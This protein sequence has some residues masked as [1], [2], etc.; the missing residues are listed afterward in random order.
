M[1]R[2]GKLVALPVALAMAANL[3]PG[4]AE[5]EDPSAGTGGRTGSGGGGGGP[6]ASAGGS[7]GVEIEGGS[8]SGGF[9]PDSAC[10]LFSAAGKQAPAAILFVVDRSASMSL[11]QK[12][13]VAQQAV[14]TAIDR[15][16]FDNV[17]LG[18][19][20]FPNP[21]KVDP[22]QCLCDYACAGN[23]AI[24][25]PL[26]GGGVNC[27]FSG[28]PQVPLTDS[29][30]NK[31]NGGAGVRQAIYQYMLTNTPVTD[32]SDA[33][34]IYDALV[35]GYTSLENY[36][37]DRRVVVLITDGGFSCT[38]LASPPRPAYSDG[39]CDDWE[40]PDTVNTLIKAKYDANNRIHTFIIGV[41]GSD[42][43][44]GKQGSYATAPYPMR[45]ALSTYAVSGAPD[46]VP[47]SCDKT[48]VFSQSGSV[49]AAPCHFDL[50]Q[51]QLQVDQ[52]AQSLTQ[53][54]GQALGCLFDLPDPTGGNTIDKEKVNVRLTI[55]G[56]TTEIC[57][58]VEPQGGVC[59]CELCWTYQGD[60]VKLLDKACEQI[61]S[62]RE[63][64][65]DIAVGCV[66][67]IH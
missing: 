17:S 50:S 37:V 9:S 38:S 47:P 54:R 11:G 3:T 66:P 58:T 64:K 24:C 1:G 12:W 10:E 33:S 36:P 18:L 23:C 57:R 59:N 42:S 16:A 28:L 7:G 32:A 43:T 22:P 51:G 31:S 25:K 8:G 55:D 14:V 20:T 40:Y 49:P 6:D 45:L 29:G 53:I 26:L 35:S 61:S 65:V 56:T 60:Q 52:L 46:L 5:G 19:L 15:D 21:T 41:P 63:A 39:A 30:T 2:F 34:P 62:A 4:C 67:K 13:A 44:G 27:G 48:A